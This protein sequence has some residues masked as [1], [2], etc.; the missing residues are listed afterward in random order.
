[1]FNIDPDAAETLIGRPSCAPSTPA[2]IP[3]SCATAT[4]RASTRSPPLQQSLDYVD[5]ALGS[6]LAELNKSSIGD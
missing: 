1:M 2:L 6:M 3:T 4:T 5:G